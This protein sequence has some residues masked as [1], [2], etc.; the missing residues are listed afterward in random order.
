MLISSWDD[1]VKKFPSLGENVDRPEV[2]AVKEY[3]ESGGILKVTGGSNF[4][5]FYPTKKMIDKRVSSLRAQRALFT[6]QIRK[7]RS[8]DRESLPFRLAFDPLYIRHQLKMLSDKEYRE[9][10]NRL[11]FSWE[12][13]LDPNTRKIIEQ[14]MDDIDYRLRVL[15]ALK[16]SP[17]YRSRKF[18]AISDAY[19]SARRDLINNKVEALQKQVD[20]I[21]REIAVLNLLKRWM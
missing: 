9:S 16:E 20:R 5:I 7:L 2:K 13:F 11:E 18:G 15:Q 3:L 17:V 10:F 4:R 1:A 12:H 14:F 6:R 8:L 21:D 19:R